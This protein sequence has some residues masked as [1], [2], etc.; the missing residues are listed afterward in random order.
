[1][2]S[3]WEAI[4]RAADLFNTQV[5]ATT[6]SLECVSA[7]S[8]AFSMRRSYDLTLH[9][10][11]RTDGMVRAIAYDRE[12][13]EGARRFP[14]RSEVEVSLSHFELLCESKAEARLSL[15]SGVGG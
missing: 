5:I 1:M 12:S 3:L 14:W 7:A 2:R 4:G 13:L 10:L 9:R 8:E 11:D 15:P 6:H